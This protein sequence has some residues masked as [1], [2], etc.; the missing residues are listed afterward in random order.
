MD[1][2]NPSLKLLGL[3]SAANWWCSSI[4]CCQESLLGQCQLQLQA[5]HEWYSSNHFF[6][7]ICPLLMVAFD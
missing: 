4:L 3:S 1:T 2:F 7:S 6:H 5:S